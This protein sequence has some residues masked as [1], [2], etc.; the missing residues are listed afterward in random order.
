MRGTN[1][2]E[3]FLLNRAHRK[4]QPFNNYLISDF[5][6]TE[7]FELAEIIINRNAV[8]FYYFTLRSDSVKEIDSY[9]D[10]LSALDLNSFILWVSA[11]VLD[12]SDSDDY[13]FCSLRF[14]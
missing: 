9:Q 10:T 12:F 6:R 8:K 13:G 5:G 7:G 3:Q 2:I 4:F 11:N 14:N 1:A